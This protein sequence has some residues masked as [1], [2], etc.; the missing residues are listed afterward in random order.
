ML[1]IPAT[2]RQQRGCCLLS[3]MSCG[4]WQRIRWPVN[5]RIKRCKRLLGSMMLGCGLP[6]PIG[7]SGPAEPT[8]LAP[9][10]RRRILID[11][12]RGKAAQ[13]C[14]KGVEHTELHESRVELKASPDE[15]L[16]VNAA[17][18][19]LAAEYELASQIVKLRY[20]VGMTLREIAEAL[21]ISPRFLDH[22]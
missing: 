18:D 12:A 20:F 9:R 22:H 13:K 10:R 11:K 15:F 4:E 17:V 3:T 6:A 2:Q 7:N 1:V 5:D 16:A 21:E 8:S 14:G 19:E